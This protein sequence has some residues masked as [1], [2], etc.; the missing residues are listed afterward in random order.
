MAL[1]RFTP[2]TDILYLL[3]LDGD[4]EAH[5]I[6][7]MLRGLNYDSV[8][9]TRSGD[10]WQLETH[11]APHLVKRRLEARG[12]DVIQI[13]HDE[14]GGTPYHMVRFAYPYAPDNEWPAAPYHPR[15][16][17]MPI[18]PWDV[19]TIVP[20]KRDT[21]IGPSGIV[22][23]AEPE[24]IPAALE[25]TGLIPVPGVPGLDAPYHTYMAD[26]DAPNS[27]PLE[28]APA[29]PCDEP[30]PALTIRY[31]QRILQVDAIITGPMGGVYARVNIS[32][33]SRPMWHHVQ[34]LQGTI[35]TAQAQAA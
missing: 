26:V 32:T 7:L 27:T 15:P 9:R 35:V 31:G 11:I 23:I 30:K 3:P 10:I 5:T 29:L 28:D 2:D 6:C 8:Y 18:Y 12:L 16:V 17:G 21:V 4:R 34:Y 1:P 20:V 22:R 14:K 25:A 19:P 33:T 13:A 24:D